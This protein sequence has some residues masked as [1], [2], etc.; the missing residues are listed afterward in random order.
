MLLA[1]AS[2]AI[3]CPFCVAT[4]QTFTKKLLHGRRS[5]CQAGKA[6]TT[7][8]PGTQ[9]VSQRFLGR[10][11]NCDDCQRKRVGEAL[12]NR[13]HLFWRG[14]SRTCS[15]SWLILEMMWSTPMEISKSTQNYILKLDSLPKDPVVVWSSFRSTWKTKMKNWL[16]IPTT[17]LPTVPMMPSCVRA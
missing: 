3:A 12:N 14:Q 2:Q 6:S 11:L 10:I 9:L 5:F 8:Q 13:S 1:N 17:N 7:D 15:W 4:T 16:G